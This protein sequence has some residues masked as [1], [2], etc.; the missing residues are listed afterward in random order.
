MDKQKVPI[1]LHMEPC[2]MLYGSLNG[3]GDWERMDTCI[4]M[5]GSLC[6]SP[7]TITLL[8][9]TTLLVNCYVPI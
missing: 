8:V 7:E 2:L 6:C 1:V 5:A 4:C 9:C 3:N